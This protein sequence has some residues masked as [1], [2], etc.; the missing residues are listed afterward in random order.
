[1]KKR[2][3][4]CMGCK[5]SSVRITP[6]RPYKPYIRGHF[7]EVAFFVFSEKVFLVANW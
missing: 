5:G 7:N 4:A 3:I 2:N 1:M 6:S